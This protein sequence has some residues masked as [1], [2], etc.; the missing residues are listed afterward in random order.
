MGLI[1]SKMHKPGKQKHCIELIL[2]FMMRP[3]QDY[4]NFI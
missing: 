2:P 1:K 3:G 4:K